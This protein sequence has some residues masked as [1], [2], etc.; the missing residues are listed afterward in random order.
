MKYYCKNCGT[1]FKYRDEAIVDEYC[2]V[3]GATDDQWIPVPDYETPEQYEKRTGK[4]FPDDGAVWIKDGFNDPQGWRLDY[5]LNAIED[6]RF[7]I[8]IADPPI[9]PPDDWKPEGE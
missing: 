3:C 5:C 7:I 2:A 4:P 1:E 9:P 6:G 8:L